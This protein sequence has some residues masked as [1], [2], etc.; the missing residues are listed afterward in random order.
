MSNNGTTPD[1]AQD[2]KGRR[3]WPLQGYQPVAPP[4]PPQPPRGGTGVIDS[5]VAKPVGADR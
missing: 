4:V 5:P 2:Q 1:K 3:P